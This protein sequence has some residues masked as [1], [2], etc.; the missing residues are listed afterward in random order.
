[1]KKPSPFVL[2]A[3]SVGLFAAVT[4]ITR[5][6]TP[7][8]T[9]TPGLTATPSVQQVA[10]FH[11]ESWGDSQLSRG[12]IV[13]KIGSVVCGTGGPIPIADA[14]LKYQVDVVSTSITPGCG[15]EGALITF[16][17]DGRQAAQTA[18]WHAGTDT[19]LNLIVGVAFSLFSGSTPVT[20]NEPEAVVP[21]INGASCGTEEFNEALPPPCIG[22]LVGYTD[23]AY[24][25]QQKAGCGVEGAPIT[26]KF[27]DAQ[28]NVVAVA[29]E[30]GTWHAWDGVSGPQQLNLTFG[31]SSGA[32]LP[33]TGTG[34]TSTGGPL[35]RPSAFAGF[36]GLCRDRL[37]TRPSPLLRAPI[38][39]GPAS[40]V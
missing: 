21:F 14:P 28:G 17:I 40:T 32:G 37:R 19:Q 11:G 4:N 30:T 35:G 29:N 39:G 18:I 2:V 36:P 31:S 15:S 1:M 24:S 25:A 5:A 20:G 22:Q 26:F 13:A 16:L 23:I 27:L 7:T 12:T 9:A 6:A 10:R 33:N 3:L 38:F 34:G 8:P